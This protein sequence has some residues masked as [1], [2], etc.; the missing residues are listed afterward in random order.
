LSTSTQETRNVTSASSRHPLSGGVAVI[1]GAA[2]GFGLEAC[3]RVAS[4][5]M[6][7]VMVDV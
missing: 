1:T 3:R 6:R 5:G 2:S 7:F 4:L